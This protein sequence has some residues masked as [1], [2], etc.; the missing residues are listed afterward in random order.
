ML[1]NDVL[2]G[3]VASTGTTLFTAP[4]GGATVYALRFNNPLAY[5]ITVSRFDN[6]LGTSIDLYTLNLAAG[7]TVSDSYN[8]VL[9]ENDYIKV[10]SSVAGTVYIG[11]VNYVL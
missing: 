7:D 9:K 5:S 10:T 2:S 3:T 11:L 4:V 8:Y 1:Y 6:L